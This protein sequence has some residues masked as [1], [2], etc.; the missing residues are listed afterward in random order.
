MDIRRGFVVEMLSFEDGSALVIRSVNRPTVL[1]TVALTYAAV[2]L[3]AFA[4]SHWIATDI[5]ALSACVGI[6]C[7][8]G[9][10][11]GF[12]GL[13]LV[14]TALQREH[15]ILRNSPAI[16]ISRRERDIRA[17]SPRASEASG[18]RDRRESLI[19]PLPVQ[20][21]I[22]GATRHCID[23]SASDSAWDTPQPVA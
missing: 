12:V 5:S 6:V 4:F 8:L 9:V 13:A 2:L 7:G 10:A 16:R 20:P 21:A 3:T 22:T 11:W 1:L 19:A 18:G 17:K 14:V 23:A 15:H